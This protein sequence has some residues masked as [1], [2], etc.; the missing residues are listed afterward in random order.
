MG[1][2]AAIAGAAG[3]FQGLRDEWSSGQNKLEYT[4]AH[5]RHDHETIQEQDNASVQCTGI[6]AR[7]LAMADEALAGF[8]YSFYY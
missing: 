4:A 7:P 6:R 1:T 8:V 5:G 3:P 2:A